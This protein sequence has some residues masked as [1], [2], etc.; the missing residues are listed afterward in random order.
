MSISSKLLNQGFTTI[1]MQ[2]S[3][4]LFFHDCYSINIYYDAGP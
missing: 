3:S 2:I 1:I 4:K